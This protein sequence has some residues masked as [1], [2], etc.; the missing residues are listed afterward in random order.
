MFG[1]KEQCK[2]GN[3]YYVCDSNYD[4]VV[5]EKCGRTLALDEYIERN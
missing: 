4:S 5:C 1:I 3:H 2:P